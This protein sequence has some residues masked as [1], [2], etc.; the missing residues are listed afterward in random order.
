MEGQL[1]T[2]ANQYPQG[3]MQALRE[4]L[5]FWQDKYDRYVPIVYSLY[6]FYILQIL[7]FLDYWKVIENY[8][9]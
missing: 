2:H 5:Y 8:K 9:K 3:E 4:N 6:Y 7:F 1:L